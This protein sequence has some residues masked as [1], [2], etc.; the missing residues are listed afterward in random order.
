MCKDCCCKKL[1]QWLLY[2]L[3][4][5]LLFSRVTAWWRLDSSSSS[6]QKRRSTAE[7]SKIVLTFVG[8]TRKA[9]SAVPAGPLMVITS[10][11]NERMREE[12]VGATATPP[13]SKPAPTD[14]RRLE[15]T[16]R[17]VR[18]GA[19]TA[20]CRWRLK[21]R[22]REQHEAARS[23][24]KQPQARFSLCSSAMCP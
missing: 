3:V 20:A 10:T 2:K 6:V 12:T 7:S 11:H 23:S 22:S 5:H 19:A 1:R 24:T 15:A 9:M 13:F 14:H 18:L 8:A 21:L 17:N 16:R 4:Q